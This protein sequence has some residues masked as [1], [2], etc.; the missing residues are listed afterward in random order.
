MQHKGN[1]VAKRRQKNGCNL[2][3]LSINNTGFLHDEV[4]ALHEDKHVFEVPISF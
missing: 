4:L 2:L 1:D 3:R